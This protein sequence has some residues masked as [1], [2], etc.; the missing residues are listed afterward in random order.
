[1]DP[2]ESAQSGQPVSVSDEQLVAMLVEQTRSEG[3]KLTGQAGLLQQRPAAAAAPSR[4]A[5]T[6][7]MPQPR[8]EPAG[9]TGRSSRRGKVSFP[10]SGT[11]ALQDPGD[12][13]LKNCTNPLGRCD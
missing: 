13:W 7:A 8:G 11:A 4:G 2:V 6:C 10:A 1:V 5:R 12:L 9:P 3:L